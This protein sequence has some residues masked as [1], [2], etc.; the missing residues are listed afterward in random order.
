MKQPE[1]TSVNKYAIELIKGK[2]SLYRTIY[3]L[4]LVKL[5]VLNTY[6]ETY[7]NTRFI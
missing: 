4:S 1:N 5:E 6:I 3:S 2:Y 7:L